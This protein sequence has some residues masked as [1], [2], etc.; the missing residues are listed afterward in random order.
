[1]QAQG[2]NLSSELIAALHYNYVE[3][4]SILYEYASNEQSEEYQNKLA[5]AWNEFYR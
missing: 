1:M 5:D 4:P 3:A 2:L